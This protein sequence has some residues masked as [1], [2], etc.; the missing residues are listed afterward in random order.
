MQL[1]VLKNNDLPEDLL[2]I[3]DEAK[4]N[5][6]QLRYQLAAAPLQ[7]NPNHHGERVFAKMVAGQPELFDMKKI[8][9]GL[10]T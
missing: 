6:E 7:A 1:R 10:C 5:T 8:Y 3:V 4:E 2:P 9:I